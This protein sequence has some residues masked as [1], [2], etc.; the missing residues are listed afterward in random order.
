MIGV[1]SYCYKFTSTA[2]SDSNYLCLPANNQE[3]EYTLTMSEDMISALSSASFNGDVILYIYGVDT[4][5][6]SGLD[7]AIRVHFWVDYAPATAKEI[8]KENLNENII[9]DAR[10]LAFKK[11]I[12]VLSEDYKEYIACVYDDSVGKYLFAFI[13][14]REEKE[15]VFGIECQ[16]IHG[17]ETKDVY[18]RGA[19]NNLYMK[20][21]ESSDGITK[22][23]IFNFGM[24]NT[25]Y[26]GGIEG[27][28][29]WIYITIV[30]NVGNESDC[31]IALPIFVE[32]ATAPTVANVYKQN[33]QGGFIEIE[34]A[35][36]EHSAMGVTGFGYDKF[37]YLAN[38]LIKVRYS[39]PIY[40]VVS[41]NYVTSTDEYETVKECESYPAEKTY[42]YADKQV[43]FEFSNEDDETTKIYVIVVQDFATFQ[44]LPVVVVV[45][46]ITPT[47]TPTQT[48]AD[49]VTIEYTV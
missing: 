11:T 9:D 40:K 2:Y 12:Q 25:S 31:I 29:R 44:S 8:I 47:I 15:Y 21:Y 18:S 43:E 13:D 26:Y 3:Q 22:G 1:G 4:K 39:E 10:N 41:C 14:A 20:F 27:K 35:D 36:Y 49:D 16:D 17:N 45:D 28:A 38:S 33:E 34:K 30:D 23:D 7:S 42:P 48:G 37:V 19:Y 6:N 32:D 24:T 46:R 5:G